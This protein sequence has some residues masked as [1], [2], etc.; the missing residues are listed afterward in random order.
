MPELLLR[1]AP[2]PF[3][4]KLPGARLKSGTGRKPRPVSGLAWNNVDLGVPRC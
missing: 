2:G 4:E 3:D 1:Q